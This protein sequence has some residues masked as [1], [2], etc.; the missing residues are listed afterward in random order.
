MKRDSYNQS[1]LI[2]VALCALSANAQE[3]WTVNEGETLKAD[4]VANAEANAMS[5][6]KFETANVT[7]T[8]T[9][10]PI[11]G[12]NDGALVDGKL[13]AKYDNTWGELKA[14]ALSSDGSVAPFYYVQG[15]GNLTFDAAANETY[16]IFC[17]STQVGFGG[18]EFTA[19]TNGISDITADKAKADAPVF[20]LAGQRVSKNA[21]GIL[22][23]N[24]KKFIAK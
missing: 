1:K 6:V 10:G 19:G 24:G 5:V 22:I 21:K 3:V 15:K 8:H 17:K 9:S 16:Y 18:F 20:N 11:S 4:Y 7:G 14:Q 2:S 13:E 12:Y 23:Q